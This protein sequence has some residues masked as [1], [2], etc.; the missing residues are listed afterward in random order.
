LE[1]FAI[2][3][4]PSKNPGSATVRSAC[5]RVCNLLDHSEPSPNLCDWTRDVIEG[6]A[7][8]VTKNTNMTD[9]P[10]GAICKY[11]QHKQV[12]THYLFSWEQTCSVDSALG[13]TDLI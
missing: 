13:Q 11:I 2:N 8:S 5:D 1:K 6:N 12:I 7:A 10:T 9:K 4:P 3:P